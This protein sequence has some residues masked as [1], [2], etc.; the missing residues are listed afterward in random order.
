MGDDSCKTHDVDIVNT[1][2]SLTI[3]N[4]TVTWRYLEQRHQER[5]VTFRLQFGYGS[6]CN[7]A[8]Y[9]LKYEKMLKT[10]MLLIDQG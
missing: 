8:V 4:Q 3:K 5:N 7:A 6:V 2:I 9:M 1:Y 10:A